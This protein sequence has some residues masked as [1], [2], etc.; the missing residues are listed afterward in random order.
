MSEKLVCEEL[1]SQPLLS[2]H[3]IVLC[4]TAGTLAPFTLLLGKSH[5][6]VA[7]PGFHLQRVILTVEKCYLSPAWSG[8]I[9]MDIRPAAF[10]E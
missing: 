5:S 3:V 1:S 8:V 10:C 6:G 7:A 9:F 2:S 4:L